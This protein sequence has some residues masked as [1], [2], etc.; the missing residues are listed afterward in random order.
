MFN[1]QAFDG[2]TLFLQHVLCLLDCYNKLEIKAIDLCRSKRKYGE[3]NAKEVCKTCLKYVA[4]TFVY[5]C[6]SR[7]KSRKRSIKGLK[8][9]RLPIY[10]EI[11]KKYV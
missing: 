2:V 9:K 10:K 5:I 8:N 11:F 7:G 3:H 4:F 1:F 6:I